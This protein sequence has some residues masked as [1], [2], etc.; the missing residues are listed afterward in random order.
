MRVSKDLVINLT[1][2]YGVFD[3]HVYLDHSDVSYETGYIYSML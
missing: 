1:T 2:C 3:T